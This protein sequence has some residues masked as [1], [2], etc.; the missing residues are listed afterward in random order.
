MGRPMN[1]R[2]FIGILFLINTAMATYPPEGYKVDQTVFCTKGRCAAKTT[3]ETCSGTG[4]VVLSTFMQRAGCYF[5]IT[6]DTCPTCNGKE[7]DTTDRVEE[8]MRG[9][10]ESRD[11]VEVEKG[12]VRVRWAGVT[13]DCGTCHGS[14][15]SKGDGKA[16]IISY[17]NEKWQVRIADKNGIKRVRQMENP[18]RL[19]KKRRRRRLVKVTYYSS[20]GFNMLLMCCLLVGISFAYHVGTHETNHDPIRW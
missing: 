5:G 15:V 12:K 11:N 6:D 3:C 14:N 16:E 13:G 9:K 4:K 17:K 2:S 18:K 20:I 7:S 10:V 1:L 19:I 8:G